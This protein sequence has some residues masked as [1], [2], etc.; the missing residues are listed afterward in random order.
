MPHPDF[1][2][3]SLTSEQ[4]TECQAFNELEPIGELDYRV[5][6]LTALVANFLKK[7]GGRVLT[8]EDAQG[9]QGVPKVQTATEIEARLRSMLKPK[10][11]DKNESK[12]RLK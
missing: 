1:L 3:P 6:T 9:R 5:A 8:P 4:I 2:L 12:K 7:K 10:G 11:K